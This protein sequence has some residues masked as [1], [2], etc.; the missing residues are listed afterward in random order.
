[1]KYVAIVKT[2]A[3]LDSPMLLK[4][5]LFMLWHMIFEN[6]K[7]CTTPHK[8]IDYINIANKSNK[9]LAAELNIS[10]STLTRM[11][12]KYYNNTPAAY[13]LQSKIESARLQLSNTN[14]TVSQIASSLGFNSVEHFSRIFKKYT[15]LAPSEYRKNHQSNKHIIRKPY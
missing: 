10:V 7:P 11:F 6:M 12:K 4:S 1:M 5:H 8:T 3:C 13:A 9:G 15:S 2:S 14:M